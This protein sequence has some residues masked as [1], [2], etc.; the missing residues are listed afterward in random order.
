VTQY[1]VTV[2]KD[3]AWLVSDVTTGYHGCTCEKQ[4]AEM[5]HER[6]QPQI[7][8]YLVTEGVDGGVNIFLRSLM[9]GPVPVMYTDQH[10]CLLPACPDIFI[11][12][13]EVSLHVVLKSEFQSTHNAV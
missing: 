6:R 2:A 3:R 13:T 10:V 5:E 12:T 7:F 8:F 1:L 11:G 9:T 4:K